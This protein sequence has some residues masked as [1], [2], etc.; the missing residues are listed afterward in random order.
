V[1]RVLSAVVLIAVVGSV[2][3]LA[4]S[5]VVLVLA[6]G[7]AA[8][9]GV[10]F[11]QL[12]RASGARGVFS[13]LV[14]SRA[15]MA[16]ASSAICFAVAGGQVSRAFESATFSLD[17]LMPLLLL[18]MAAGTLIL[19]PQGP[20]V[21]SPLMLVMGPYYL[22]MPLGMLARLQG[23]E[24]PMMLCWFLVVMAVSDTAQYYTGRMLG[25]TKLAPT[26]SPA[27]TVEG[28]LGGLFVASVVGGGLAA[29]G[30]TLSPA[31]SHWP[32]SVPVAAALALFL[33][34]I[35]IVGDLFESKLKR[36]AGAKDTS[37]LIP[38]HGG[39][40]DRLDSYL[41]AAPWYFAAISLLHR[42][43]DQ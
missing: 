32:L 27:K 22:G 18:L 2:I 34:G 33:A 21:F 8:A 20:A 40:L 36:S 28:A 17:V 37:A 12:A 31:G 4:P 14:S 23:R 11:S 35:G 15:F 41:M 5:W 6:I 9:C 1:T 10:E 24:G 38:G 29:L 30:R 13:G 42:L 7:L 25:R 19:A 26:I 16:L 3:W 39:V 43:P